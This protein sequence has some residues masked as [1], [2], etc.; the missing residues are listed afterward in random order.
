[1]ADK[2]KNTLE[3]FKE[4]IARGNVIDMAVGVIM[5]SAFGSIVT[6]LVNDLL[7]PVIGMLIGGI[8]F[9][10]LC[11]TVGSAKLNYGNLIQSIVNFLIIAWCIFSFMKA[12][13]RFQKKKEEEAPAPD[14]NTVLLQEIRDLLKEQNQK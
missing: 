2:G 11:I 5:G 14:E 10:S 12:V 6:S 8:D 9:T 7:M 13:Q 4:F 3:E 1:M